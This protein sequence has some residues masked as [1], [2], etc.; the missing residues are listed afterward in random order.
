MLAQCLLIAS[1]FT[2]TSRSWKHVG[3]FVVSDVGIW[4]KPALRGSTALWTELRLEVAEASGDGWP[5]TPPGETWHLQWVVFVGQKGGFIH[6]AERTS[7]HKVFHYWDGFFWGKCSY[8]VISR[9]PENGLWFHSQHFDKMPQ[10]KGYK[11]DFY[12]S[13]FCS[14]KSL[15]WSQWFP[16][17]SHMAPVKMEQHWKSL[18]SIMALCE[19]STN[20][21]I[22]STDIVRTAGSQMQMCNFFFLFKKL[23]NSVIKLVLRTSVA[24]F[25]DFLRLSL[26]SGTLVLLA[27]AGL[28]LK[29]SEVPLQ[30][31]R[32]SLRAAALGNRACR[33]ALSWECGRTELFAGIAS[34][35]RVCG[36]NSRCWKIREYG[37]SLL[38]PWCTPQM[39]SLIAIYFFIQRLN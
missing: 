3:F 29:T 8:S 4:E 5:P 34:L 9:K 21:G 12:K 26:H 30:V 32:N 24:L 16:S 23:L 17:S 11:R 38:C 14:P 37:V 33:R 28:I 13:G 6:R 36:P 1:A 19:S 10:N 15:K 25:W 39:A 27:Y 35:G 7:W 20:E 31:T 22:S 18:P 2:V